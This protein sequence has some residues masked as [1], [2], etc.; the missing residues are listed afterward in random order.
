M[1]KWA[2][3][4]DADDWP[5]PYWWLDIG[6][7]TMLVLLDAINEGESRSRNSV[8][9]KGVRRV[10]AATQDGAGIVYRS[11]RIPGRCGRT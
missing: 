5:V 1:R 3:D 11:R 2:D 9:G 6:C 4:T 10:E 8:A 7:T